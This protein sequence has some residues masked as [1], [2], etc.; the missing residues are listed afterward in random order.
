MSANL[1]ADEA[2]SMAAILSRAF[3]GQT[4]MPAEAAQ[5]ILRARFQEADLKRVEQ[6]LERKQEQPL[7]DREEAQLQDY[8]QAD[9]VL[10]VLK[11]KARQ[12][13]QKA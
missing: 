9:C 11:A 6:L 3:D 2:D 12:S 13:L 4:A 1:A 8:L 7:S 10:T 5:L